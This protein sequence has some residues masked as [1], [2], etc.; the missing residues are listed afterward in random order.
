[1]LLTINMYR[2][3]ISKKNKLPSGDTELMRVYKWGNRVGYLFPNTKRDLSWIA[4]ER[5]TVDYGT[6]YVLESVI[7]LTVQAPPPIVDDIWTEDVYVKNNIITGNLTSI[8]GNG[9]IIKAYALR[10][11][12]NLSPELLPGVAD[13]AEVGTPSTEPKAPPPLPASAEPQGLLQRPPT[14]LYTPLR[15]IQNRTNDR[16]K[17]AVYQ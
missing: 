2:L 5:T 14:D 10:H 16:G 6:D 12:I 1:M 4:E 7:P 17:N 9:E 11:G 8:V 13:V 15:Y 3:T